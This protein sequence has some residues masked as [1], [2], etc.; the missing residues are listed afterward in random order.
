MTCSINRP[1]IKRINRDIDTPWS[2]HVRK[3]G[4]NY[5]TDDDSDTRAIPDVRKPPKIAL[6]KPRTFAASLFAARE[7]TLNLEEGRGGEKEARKDALRT[8][9]EG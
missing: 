7:Q 4:A 1:S 5:R 2:R 9:N 6:I 8:K 3:P